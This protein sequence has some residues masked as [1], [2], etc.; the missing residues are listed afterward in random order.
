MNRPQTSEDCDCVD[1]E[2]H[3]TAQQGKGPFCGECWE[4]LNDPDQA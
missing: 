3:F 2:F 4:S 1:D